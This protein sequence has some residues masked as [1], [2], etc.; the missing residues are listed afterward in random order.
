MIKGRSSYITDLK[1]QTTMS[2]P[3]C[4]ENTL[5]WPLDWFSYL[6][7]EA[8]FFAVLPLAPCHLTLSFTGLLRVQEH[9]LQRREP[10]KLTGG[11]RSTETALLSG[12]PP[13]AAWTATT[14]S[15]CRGTTTLLNM[16]T[17]TPNRWVRLT[18]TPATTFSSSSET[19]TSSSTVARSELLAPMP[20]T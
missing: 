19:A 9:R 11:P 18:L 20:T 15:H 10:A 3:K 16:A 1:F 5:S 17:A 8:S 12:S 2:R 13:Q 4:L 14:I 6:N 7:S